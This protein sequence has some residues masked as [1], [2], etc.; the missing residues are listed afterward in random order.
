MM[1]RAQLQL[2]V[3]RPGVSR[4]YQT[5]LLIRAQARKNAA[6]LTSMR[7]DNLRVIT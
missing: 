7:A 6:M 1:K 2:I 5:R 4:K 3:S